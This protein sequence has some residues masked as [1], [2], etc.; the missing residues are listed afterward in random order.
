MATER[1]SKKISALN[2]IGMIPITVEVALTEADARG[3]Q[4]VIIEAI[5]IDLAVRE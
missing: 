4:G 2:L 3:N 1:I 5:V